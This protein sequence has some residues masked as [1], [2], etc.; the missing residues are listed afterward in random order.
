MCPR[1]RY[2]LVASVLNVV[3]TLQVYRHV[4]LEGNQLT[5]LG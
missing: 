4:E 5:T 1:E 2:I 3:A